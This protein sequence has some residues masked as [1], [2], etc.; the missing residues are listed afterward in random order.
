MTKYLV[1]AKSFLPWLVIAAAFIL[2]VSPLWAVLG[3]HTSPTKC[4]DKIAQ[5]VIQEHPDLS[6]DQQVE[7]YLDLK[8]EKEGKERTKIRQATESVPFGGKDDKI[9]QELT[10][11]DPNVEYEEDAI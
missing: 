7:K 4:T 9:K 3:K 1:K 10:I 5:H 2:V 11:C 8:A 6:R